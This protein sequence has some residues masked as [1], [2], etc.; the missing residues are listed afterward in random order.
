MKQLSKYL[1]AMALTVHSLSAWSDAT[2]PAFI[3]VSAM[4]EVKAMP[5][6]INISVNIEKSNKTK[7]EAKADVDTITK[8]V[9]NTLTQIN[10]EKKHIQ[11][12]DI[13]ARPDYDWS[14]N[15]QTIKG[16]IVSRTVNIELHALENYSTLAEA[17]L[18]LDITRMDQQG[19]GFNN[20]AI[21]QNQAL[22]IALK[23]A[24]TQAQVI[25][26]AM[27][28]PIIGIQEINSSVNDAPMPMYEAKL[29]R[30]VMSASADT[31]TDA[32]LEIKPQSI[33]SS[34]NISYWIKN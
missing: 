19:V 29:S 11:A 23:K 18:K 9:L 4:G 12:S 10:I 25:A 3:R 21:Y 33:S 2:Q 22:V 1:I 13:F 30:M 28:T 5:D 15:K 31:P 6:F 16:E 14:N 26:D 17:L 27:N 32:P 7:S 8:Q 34:V 24:Q 20:I